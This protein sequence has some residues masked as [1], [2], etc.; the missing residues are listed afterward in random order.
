MDKIRI[1]TVALLFCACASEE[2]KVSEG[3]RQG[4]PPPV[5]AT[6]DVGDGEME[7]RG[8]PSLDV[9]EGGRVKLTLTAESDGLELFVIAELADTWTGD[10]AE[11]ATEV[12]LVEGAESQI[13][14][15]EQDGAWQY[16][17][18]VVKLELV[19]G[20]V[21]GSLDVQFA[22]RTLQGRFEGRVVLSCWL[23]GSAGIVVSDAADEAETWSGDN[24]GSSAFCQSVREALGM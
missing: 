18:G 11:L 15:S 12:R 3:L 6:V 5:V 16:G 17:H 20:V 23:K 2:A 22:D 19:E 21:R 7:L 4:P 24:Y 14:L 10:A 1:M 9:R 13:G 8:N